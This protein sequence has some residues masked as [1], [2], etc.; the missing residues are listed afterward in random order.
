M[1]RIVSKPLRIAIEG[2]HVAAGKPSLLWALKAKSPTWDY[3]PESI[4]TT[5]KTYLDLFYEDPT[6]A[7]F[8]VLQSAII[9]GY[10]NLMRH[11][12]KALVQVYERSAFSTVHVFSPAV[13]EEGKFMTVRGMEILKQ[14]YDNEIFPLGE[15]D[16]F[17][18]LRTQPDLCYHQRIRKDDTG[19][20][21]DIRDLI[22]GRIV[23]KHHERIF[24]CGQLIGKNLMVIDE[25]ETEHSIDEKVDAVMRFIKN[26]HCRNGNTFVLGRPAIWNPG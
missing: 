21:E 4:K 24:G 16:A 13:V 10:A 1:E 25:F 15:I 5:Y 23:H 11:P 26:G 18:Y 8:M 19:T 2:S 17:I 12:T 7:S 9:S 20:K 22:F 6:P 14:Q 3:F